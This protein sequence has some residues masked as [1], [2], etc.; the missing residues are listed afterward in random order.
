MSIILTGWGSLVRAR[1]APL[2]QFS[3]NLETSRF[4]HRKKTLII[5][6]EYLSKCRISF[7]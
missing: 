6:F 5:T 3:E 4:S 2:I 7:L 1:Y